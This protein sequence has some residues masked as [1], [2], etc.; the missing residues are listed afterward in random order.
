MRGFHT[1]VLTLSTR[2][3]ISSMQGCLGNLIVGLQTYLQALSAIRIFLHQILT[4]YH[5]SMPPLKKRMTQPLL[6]K[7]V[8]CFTNKAAPHIFNCIFHIS[9]SKPFHIPQDKYLLGHCKLFRIPK[10]MSCLGAV[11]KGTLK[12]FL[13][14]CS[15]LE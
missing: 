1:W 3:N 4:P 13:L 9:T 11:C 5:L 2:R 14:G 7:K 6:K 8:C 15:N 10:T 12:R